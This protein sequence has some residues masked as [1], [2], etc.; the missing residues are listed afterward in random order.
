[1]FNNGALGRLLRDG[2]ARQKQIVDNPTLDQAAS[3]ISPVFNN[4][5]GSYGADYV[6]DMSNWAARVVVEAFKVK[7]GAT[8]HE[9]FTTSL[10]L[11]GDVDFNFTSELVLTAYG[12]LTSTDTFKVS[13]AVRVLRR[14]AVDVESLESGDAIR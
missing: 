5:L 8:T 1:M 4:S 13:H 14:A 10:G 12:D 9:A 11:S 2:E 6:R 3:R 7:S